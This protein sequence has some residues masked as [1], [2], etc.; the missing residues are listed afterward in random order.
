LATVDPAVKVNVTPAPVA[1]FVTVI[2]PVLVD[3]PP[4][5]MA[6]VG[7][8][9]VSVAPVTRNALTRL[10]VLPGTVT[11]LAVSAALGEITHEALTVVVV[12]PVTVH[13]MPLPL[14]ITAVVPAR[15]VPV[16]TTGTV[17]PRSPNAGAI[18]LSEGIGA[19]MVNVTVLVVPS[20][21]TTAT[22][23]DPSRALGAIVNVA[24]TVVL[25]TI[26]M[27]LTVTPLPDTVMA[28]A[29]SRFVPVS[30]TFT[31]VPTRPDEVPTVVPEVA[32]IDVRVGVT[33]VRSAW[34]ST[35]PKSMRPSPSGLGRGFPKK[36]NFGTTTPAARFSPASIPSMAGEFGASA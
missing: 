30:V 32:M 15:F 3:V 12:V 26:P 21:V 4:E 11:L 1:V 34:V 27:S 13:A 24:T 9:I 14:I 22:F 10:L 19:F 35:A 28:D 5:F 29:P 8:E 23:L 25:L 7:A 20:G 2:V 18:L 36:S 33:R 31:E 6:G 16:N 17:V